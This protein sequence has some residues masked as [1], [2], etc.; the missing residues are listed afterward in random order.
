MAYTSIFKDKETNKVA[1]GTPSG[2]GYKS[3]FGNQPKKE[4]IPEQQN[5]KTFTLPSFLG[6]GTYKSVFGKPNELVKTPRAD[7]GG[8]PTKEGY[9]RADIIPVGLGGVNASSTNITYEPNL[10]LEQQKPFAMT[11]TDKYLKEVIY[12]QYK[13]GNI[14]LPEARV[15]AT[16]YLRDA[17][18]GLKDAYKNQ[19]I[20]GVV[21]E[22]ADKIVSFFKGQ[23]IEEKTMTP[24]ELTASLSSRNVKADILK[25]GKT[26]VLEKVDFSSGEMKPSKLNLP[27]TNWAYKSANALYNLVTETEANLVNKLTKTVETKPTLP[28]GV[29]QKPVMDTPAKRITGGTQ[30]ATASLGLIPQW[31]AFGGALKVAE[32]TPVLK[33]PA[34]VITWGLEKF[35]QA[36]A[37]VGGKA[38]D[39][40]PLPE[41]TK[42]EIRPAFE[43]LASLGA[44]LLG[45]KKT[46]DLVGKFST[47]VKEKIKAKQAEKVEITPE[48]GKQIVEQAKEEFAPGLEYSKTLKELADNPTPEIIAKAEIKKAELDKVLEQQK[49]IDDGKIRLTEDFDFNDTTHPLYKKADF[50]SNILMGLQEATAGQRII[51]GS[52]MDREVI[53]ISSTF[54]SW[55]PGHLRKNS[56]IKPVLDHILKGTIPKGSAQLDLYKEIKKKFDEF[57]VEDKTKDIIAS[58]IDFNATSVKAPEIIKAPETFTPKVSKSIETKA[59]EAKLTKGYDNLP[60][61]E[62]I[63][64]KEQAKLATDLINSDRQKARAIIRGE[65]PLPQGLRATSLISAMEEYIKTHPNPEIAYE[66][67]N[68]ILTKETSYAAQELRLAAERQPDSFAAKMLE[69]KRAKEKQVKNVDKKIKE[70]K[71]ELKQETEKVNLEKEDLIWDNFLKKI[72][73]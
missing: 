53:G 7:Y 31:L 24:K 22:M 27:E 46:A 47:V 35:G 69:I 56:I 51:R 14:S 66:L 15:M 59:V 38:V 68:S 34:K 19:N 28:G 1:S 42:K 16:S 55:I 17:Q 3:V 6:G 40:S 5:I 58:E 72:S 32:Q 67:A 23:K 57:G 30:I 63:N 65:E 49:P 61:V 70:G 29:V 54:P 64:I 9:E 43:E 52:G 62:K 20:G 71:K 4:T 48:V 26:P 60:Q 73:C 12:P 2:T 36:G 11:A 25:Q 33:Y 18:E 10:P 37:Y 8:L 41:E 21:G 45:A 44:Q 39:V 13:S 50:E